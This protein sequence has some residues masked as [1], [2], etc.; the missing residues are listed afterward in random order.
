MQ[1]LR[2][3]DWIR[4]ANPETQELRET[5]VDEMKEIKEER[6]A[7]ADQRGPKLCERPPRMDTDCL[8]MD[9][10]DVDVRGVNMDERAVNMDEG[11]EN[12]NDRDIRMGEGDVNMDG[13]ILKAAEKKQNQERLRLTELPSTTYQKKVPIYS[14][15]GDP[16]SLAP[17]LESN[18][19]SY[20]RGT[21][22]SQDRNGKMVKMD[23]RIGMEEQRY[24]MRPRVQTDSFV[25]HGQRRYNHP[26]GPVPLSRVRAGSD[27]QAKTRSAS[28]NMPE[29][30]VLGRTESV[31]SGAR[32]QRSND[33]VQANYPTARFEKDYYIIDV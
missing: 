10:R 25:S 15:M 28:K 33:S 2:V 24:R 21:R 13:R 1:K 16:N 8:N 7:R 17:L 14:G 12:M 19:A 22:H 18:S 11:G 26:Q 4:Q 30:E 27:K 3:L 6:S 9:E 31:R 20:A 29:S 23:P 5:K 32:A